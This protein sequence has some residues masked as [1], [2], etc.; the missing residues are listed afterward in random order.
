MI[1]DKCGKATVKDKN[2]FINKADG[3]TSRDPCINDEGDYHDGFSEDTWYL[4][5]KKYPS[6]ITKSKCGQFDAGELYVVDKAKNR[7]TAQDG[8]IKPGD[9]V[10]AVFDV[11]AFSGDEAKGLTATVEGVQKWAD[12]KALTLGGAS[13]GISDDDFEMGEEDLPEDD[14]AASMM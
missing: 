9:T 1:V 5:G 4:S 12:G 3:S 14:D 13:G 7:I 8:N 2:W 10:N 6:D 11:Y